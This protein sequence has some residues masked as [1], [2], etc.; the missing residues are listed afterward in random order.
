LYGAQR[1]VALRFSAKPGALTRFC[2]NLS[3]GRISI[4]VYGI[5][6]WS[7]GV[8]RWTTKRLWQERGI[9]AASPKTSAARRPQRDTTSAAGTRLLALADGFERFADRLEQ[10]AEADTKSE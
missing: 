8:E 3:N 4:N 2:H 1:G 7:E 10:E 6:D 9:F 5:R